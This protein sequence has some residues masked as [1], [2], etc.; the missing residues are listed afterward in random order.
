M[1]RLLS[2]I[3][4]LMFCFQAV[5]VMADGLLIMSAPTAKA[6]PFKDVSE[7]A[8]YYGDVK[9]AYDMGLINGKDSADTYKPD[10]NMT[11]AEAIKLAACMHELYTTGK[12]TLANG[13][14]QWYS[15][16]VEY[17]KT[18]GIIAKDYDYSAL[19]T[20][21]GYME[22]F[23]KALPDEA[24]N[25]KN[26]VPKGFVPDVKVSDAYYDAVYKLYRA[27]I[28]AGSDAQYSC[29]PKDNIKRSEVAAILARMMIPSKRVSVG[30]EPE[31]ENELTFGVFSD[32]HN[33]K[34]DFDNVM[35]TIYALTDEGSEL[36]GIVMVGDIVYL[37][38]KDSVPG[39]G[40]YAMIKANPKFS[41]LL[42]SGKVVY[43]M[44]NHE[45]PLN[46]VAEDVTALSK[47]VFKTE[48]GLD[49]EK[50]TVYDGYHFITAGPKDYNNSL[51]PEQEQFVMDSVKAALKADPEKPVFLILHQPVDSTL[52]GTG[53]YNKYSDVFESFI[54]S[55][56][57]LVV[58]SGHMH[59][60]SSDPQ[61]IYQVPG[62][63]TFVYT[64]SLMGGNGTKPPTATERHRTWAN[65]GIM[66]RINKDTNVVTLKRFYSGS[67][68]PKYLEGGDWTLDIPAM[69]DED[70]DTTPNLD[71]Y[72]YTNARADLSKAPYFKD[73]DAITVKE[74]TEN[75]AKVVV[76]L[77]QQGAED[78]NSVVAFY[79]IEVYNK[80]KGEV[81]KSV[82]TPSDY[83]LK[84]KSSTYTYNLVD[85]PD[86]SDFKVTVTPVTAWYVKAEKP[87][88]A[89]FSTP[90]PKFPAVTLS[91]DNISRYNVYEAKLLGTY[92]KYND[93]IHM[94]YS[95]VASAKFVVDI[96]KPG[97]YRVFLEASA[98]GSADLAL[99]V[100]SADVA[101][102]E[103]ADGTEKVNITN[104]VEL[105][106]DTVTV[107]TANVSTFRDVICADIE[108]A[109][110]GT[111]TVRFK[112]AKTPYTIGVKT[113]KVV[114][115]IE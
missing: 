57:R 7:N 79:D 25:Q 88:V 50:V 14:E 39:A 70:G 23:A 27:G 48:T 35:N 68:V 28:V 42:S 101:Y 96:T 74:I 107:N 22:I 111:Y 9:S 29:N 58:F 114:E 41:S 3:L 73:G 15:T 115:I 84:N 56:P 2:L 55:Q 12:V 54:K 75:S 105:H 49:P 19:A 77:P 44:G 95:T 8:W 46:N 71:V 106:T 1:K 90:A 40:T 108:F 87:L 86:T 66:L 32:L 63:T 109:K 60:P 26:I 97:K 81:L 43:A 76:P 16:Y 53:H 33:S 69:I 17:C 104:E 110:E 31:K 13:A 67:G 20:R 80:T 82:R 102:V 83:F 51:T 62:G 103:K 59:Y 36:D 24:L 112:K 93:F 65:Q 113:L 91:T 6:F 18:N 47:E 4:V 30:F 100:C 37:A 94:G 64:S 52:F 92:T 34:N 72:K 61:T 85:L 78:E 98:A 38:A 99:T 11:Y 21:A 89:E 10:V 45:F 5:S